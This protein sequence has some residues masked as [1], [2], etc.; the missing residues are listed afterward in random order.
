[1]VVRFWAK[2]GQIGPKWDKPGTFSDKISVG[3]HCGTVRPNV[4]KSDLK[5]FGFVPF[6]A[7]LTHFGLN[8]EVPAETRGQA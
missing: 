6:W 3:L 5:K 7:N 4:L 2:L 1:M 8:S